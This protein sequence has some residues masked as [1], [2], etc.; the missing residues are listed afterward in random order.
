MNVDFQEVAEFK[1]LMPT[2]GLPNIKVFFLNICFK[3][4]FQY[5]KDH[6]FHVANL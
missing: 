1:L 2:Q 6:M 4:I 3:S 5:Q